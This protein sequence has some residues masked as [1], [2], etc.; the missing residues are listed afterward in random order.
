MVR[1]TWPAIAVL[2]L[3]AGCASASPSSPSAAPAGPQTPGPETPGP[4]TPAPTESTQP[5]DAGPRPT[6]AGDLY[7]GFDF[8]QVRV[9]D[10]ADLP[11]GIP[12]P[13]PFG[14]VIDTSLGAFEGELLAIDYDPRFFN[15]AVAFYGTWI[16]LEGIDA[17]ELIAM[18]S[19]ATGW[20]FERDGIPVR[21]EIS[22]AADASSA[23][24]HIYWG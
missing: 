12:V 21:I 7:P 24:V 17:D 19:D 4:Q 1:R 16:H 20:E 5:T 9:M 22:R 6:S 11:A 8:D 14:G 23:K 13:V 10:A 3:L 2:I 15:T 18:G